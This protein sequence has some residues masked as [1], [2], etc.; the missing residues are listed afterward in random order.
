MKSYAVSST[1]SFHTG[2][3]SALSVHPTGT[4]LRYYSSLFL[5][6]LFL[7]LS[8]I[9]S[10]IFHYPSFP[11]LLVPYFCIPLLSI[12]SLHFFF[13]SLHSCSCPLPY[14][15]FSLLSFLHS[16]LTTFSSAPFFFFTSLLSF[17]FLTSISPLHSIHIFTTRE[18]RAIDVKGRHMVPCRC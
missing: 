18:V 7:S 10:I 5:S 2:E 13:L 15:L 3:V 8:C 9:F 16:T 14:F 1:Y 17:L 12:I 11:H 6:P 4:Y